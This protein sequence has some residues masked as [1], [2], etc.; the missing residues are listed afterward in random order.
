VLR[1]KL[2]SNF[3]KNHISFLQNVNSKTIN[4]TDKCKGNIQK[5][6]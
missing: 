4:E 6:Q 1:V 5:Q 3:I 2:Y